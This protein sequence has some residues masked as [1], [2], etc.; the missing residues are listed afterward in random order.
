LKSLSA[1]RRVALSTLLCLSAAPCPAIADDVQ[2]EIVMGCIYSMGEFG[3]EAVEVCRKENVAAVEAL[4]DYPERHAQ[5]IENCGRRAMSR[6]GWAA[7]KRCAD[8]DIEAEAALAGYPDR[9]A[10]LIAECAAQTTTQGPKA[11]K[12]CVDRRLDSAR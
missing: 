10:S 4:R 1:A 12:E 9:L 5:I 2:A 8:Q 6:G 11:V 7:V 3:S